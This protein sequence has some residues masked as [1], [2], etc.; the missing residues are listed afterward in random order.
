[1]K[2]AFAF[3]VAVLLAC[4]AAAQQAG[5]PLT[6]MPSAGKAVG[7]VR[8]PTA[9]R[10]FVLAPDLA[11]VLTTAFKLSPDAGGGSVIFWEGEP[12]ARFTVLFVPDSSA[13]SLSAVAVTLGGA[14]PDPT[15]QPPK[16]GPDPPP[17]TTAAKAMILM[18]TETSDQGHEL[19][20]Q[21]IRRDKSLSAKVSILDP[22]T[23]D[24]NNQLDK[25]VQAALAFLGNRPLPRLL[26]QNAAGGFVGDEALPDSPDKTKAALAARGIK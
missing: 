14:A 19:I 4:S 25:T 8:A 20:R 22:D 12:G 1:M 17:V 11:P 16:P 3:S 6:V 10:W 24:E 21:A 13:E 9:G 26:Y 23:R 18:E 15:P 7:L 2:R 5:T